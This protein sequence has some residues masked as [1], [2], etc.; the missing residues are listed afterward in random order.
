MEGEIMLDLFEEATGTDQ[1]ATRREN[2]IGEAEWRGAVQ[3]V[4]A[5]L[6]VLPGRK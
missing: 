1:I 2:T 5:Y 4:R 3:E 6:E